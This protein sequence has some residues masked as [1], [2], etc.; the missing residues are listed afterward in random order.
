MP[1]LVMSLVFRKIDQNPM[2]FFAKPIT[3]KI[4]DGTRRNFLNPQL[5]LHLGFVEQKLQG[6]TAW[7]LG[8]TLTGADIMMSFPLQAAI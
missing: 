6:K 1:L 4:T 8:D 2:P 7:L 5:E 3:R